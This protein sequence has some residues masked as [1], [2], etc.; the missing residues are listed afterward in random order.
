[1]ASTLSSLFC[2]ARNAILLS[3]HLR[4]V[5]SFCLARKQYRVKTYRLSVSLKS[6]LLYNIN[7]QHIWKKNVR[8]YKL[9]AIKNWV[10]KIR[11]KNMWWS[12]S[13]CA[14]TRYAN[15]YTKYCIFCVN[16][17]VKTEK[18]L[19][20]KKVSSQ[21]LLY[22]LRKNIRLFSIVKFEDILLPP[23]HIKLGLMENFVRGSSRDKYEIL[24]KSFLGLAMQK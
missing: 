16:G 17:I 3:R 13:N 22:P 23:L 24:L 19:N 6:V 15:G 21:R 2:N 7:T 5:D 1:M 4:S 14:I 12:E 9:A 11:M 18:S 20:Q 10:W 8:H